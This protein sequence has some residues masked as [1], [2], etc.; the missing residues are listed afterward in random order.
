MAVGRYTIRKVDDNQPEIVRALRSCGFSVACCHVV[1][2]GFP[3]IAVARNGIMMLVEIKD[4]KK[5]KSA[6]QLTRDEMTFKEN[7]KAYIP[8]LESLDDVAAMSNNYEAMVREL[9]P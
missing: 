3:D 9:F 2:K 4:G 7:W 5:P 1:S 6:R 8:I